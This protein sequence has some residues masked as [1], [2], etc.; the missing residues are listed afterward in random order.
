[1]RCHRYDC[2]RLLLHQRPHSDTVATVYNAVTAA[3]PPASRRGS[4]RIVQ[5][6]VERHADAVGL[7][8]LVGNFL[9]HTRQF[10][11]AAREYAFALARR[12]RDPLLNL[13]SFLGARQA[14]WLMPT[15]LSADELGDG[16]SFPIND[17]HSV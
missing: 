7:R 17:A 16:R 1:M 5:R 9:L 4:I 2:A 3:T 13:R 12:P 10:E 6:L 11:L 15:A 8:V 14:Y